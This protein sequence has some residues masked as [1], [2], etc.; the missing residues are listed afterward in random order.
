MKYLIQLVQQVESI[1]TMLGLFRHCYQVNPRVHDFVKKHYYSKKEIQD[2]RYVTLTHL[3]KTI[4]VEIDIEEDL[5][6]IAQKHFKSDLDHT[7]QDFKQFTEKLDLVKEEI[8][9]M[10][11]DQK[12]DME[13]IKII[14]NDQKKEMEEFS[15]KLDLIME[16]LKT[17]KTQQLL[18]SDSDF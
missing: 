2:G 8:K 9:K 7:E 1:E 4:K 13:E 17:L 18:V 11:T 16:Q 6:E 10:K 3:K 15:N 5:K 12:K 14:K